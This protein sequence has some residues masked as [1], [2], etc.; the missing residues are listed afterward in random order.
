[1]KAAC[2]FLLLALA[3]SGAMAVPTPDECTPLVAPQPLNE[4]AKLIGTMKMISGFTDHVAY[5]AILKITDNTR[6]TMSADER[7]DKDLHFFEEMKLNGTCYGTKGNITVDG[8]VMSA[9]MLNFSSTLQMLPT[10]DGCMVMNINSSAHDLKTFLEAYGIHLD[11][12]DNDEIH[13]HALYLFAT[14]ENS[15]K[16]AELEHFKKQAACLGFSGEPNFVLDPKH[17]YCDK[18]KVIMLN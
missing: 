15:V 7:N 6:F 12:V 13:V 18:D 11:N 9:K 2:F 3:C 5:N 10:C 4:R 8:H 17:E 16:D 14:D 1:M